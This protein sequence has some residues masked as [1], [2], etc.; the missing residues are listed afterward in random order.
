MVPQSWLS[1]SAEKHYVIPKTLPQDITRANVE[2]SI[3]RLSEGT[4]TLKS[5]Y[6]NA[7]FLQKQREIKKIGADIFRA[8]N[9]FCRCV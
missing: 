2:R 1:E 5:A 4:A 9:P 6:S 7:Q 3:T 8:N